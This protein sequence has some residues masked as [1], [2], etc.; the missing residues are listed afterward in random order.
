MNSFIFGLCLLFCNNASAMMQ[1][2]KPH[3]TQDKQKFVNPIHQGQYQ[4][5]PIESYEESSEGLSSE[6][7][8]QKDLINNEQQQQSSANYESV[9]HGNPTLDINTTQMN[10]TYNKKTN[11]N[12]DLFQKS[13]IKNHLT[14]NIVQQQKPNSQT[15]QIAQ[16]S[17]KKTN[18]LKQFVPVQSQNINITKTQITKQ[19]YLMKKKQMTENENPNCLTQS[20]VLSEN[21]GD[22]KKEKNRI[23]TLMSISVDLQ[24]TFVQLEN[25]LRNILK[26]RQKTEDGITTNDKNILLNHMS[27]IREYVEMQGDYEIEISTNE[28]HVVRSANAKPTIFNELDKLEGFLALDNRLNQSF[29]DNLDCAIK[30]L[31]DIK[32]VYQWI[33]EG[34]NT[35]YSE[36]IK[37][38]ERIKATI[39]QNE[40][41][42]ITKIDSMIQKIITKLDKLNNQK[43]VES[44][45]KYLYTQPNDIEQNLN[46]H[47]IHKDQTIGCSKFIIHANA[48]NTM[49]L[50]F[51]LGILVFIDIIV[52]AS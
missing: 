31:L 6:G 36:T 12:Q 37:D 50:L 32:G 49:R 42:K 16:K 35:K 10:P 34:T 15:K 52:S 5:S 2:A 25:V 21:L 43:G 44:E 8:N 11:K 39:K 22:L 28:G 3:V 20:I 51:G 23:E 1:T 38:I 29:Q 4:Q 40:N 45:H 26:I 19:Q 41:E 47:T 33:I 24:K 14:Q 9:R 48:Q 7:N 18:P 46:T 13:P 30:S 27:M 17:D